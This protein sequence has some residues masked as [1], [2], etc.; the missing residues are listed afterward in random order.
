MTCMKP[1][2]IRTLRSLVESGP[3]GHAKISRA[4]VTNSKIRYCDSRVRG[5]RP[6]ATSGGVPG[7]VGRRKSDAVR[8]KRREK[9]YL[10]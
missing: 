8:R 10:R 6:S 3:N 9:R 4:S 1:E 2:K 5:G 7:G